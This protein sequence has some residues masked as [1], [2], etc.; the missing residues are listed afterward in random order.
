MAR[1]AGIQQAMAVDIDILDSPLAPLRASPA[2][3]LALL[4]PW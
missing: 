1:R 3:S 4:F 2:A